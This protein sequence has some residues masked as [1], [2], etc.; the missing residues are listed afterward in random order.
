MARGVLVHMAT[1]TGLGSIKLT[2]LPVRAR[3]ENIRMMLEYAGIKYDDEVV[4]GPA[5]QA[6]K[7]RQPFD[8]LPGA[9]P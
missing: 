9:D 3:A 4:A 8:K 6:I 2:Y 1:A 7:S 5:W